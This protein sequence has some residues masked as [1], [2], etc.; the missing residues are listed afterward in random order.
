VV[1]S[2]KEANDFLARSRPGPISPSSPRRSP[3]TPT[4]RTRAASELSPRPRP[5]S[6][7]PFRAQFLKVARQGLADLV[8]RS[9]F[10]KSSLTSLKTAGLGARISSLEDHGPAS[11][12]TVALTSPA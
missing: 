8:G 9:A 12:S 2:E 6:N 7:W 4:P 11:F 3:S 1:A 10:F 5:A